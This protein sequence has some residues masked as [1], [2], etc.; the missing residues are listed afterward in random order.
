MKTIF[1]LLFLVIG[2][3]YATAQGSDKFSEDYTAKPYQ[4]N[5]EGNDDRIYAA[6]GIEKLP[7]FPGGLE[8]FYR[9]VGRQ[10]K[11]SDFKGKIIVSFIVEKTGALSEIKVLRANPESAG[12]EMVRVLKSSP[13]WIPA[14]QNN[15][16]VRC[17]YTI[18]ITLPIVLSDKKNASTPKSK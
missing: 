8:A 7:E 10:Y 15:K 13:N 4:E 2:T 1:K 6:N 17:A 9:F 18:P 14:K 12:A 3:S 11:P 16:V 5:K